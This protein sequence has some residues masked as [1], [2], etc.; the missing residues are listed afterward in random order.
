VRTMVSLDD[1]LLISAKHRSAE[2]NVSLARVIENALRDAVGNP[3]TEGKSKKLIT[4]S[5]TGVKPG[6]DLDSGRSL[7]DIMGDPS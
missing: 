4:A 2:E 6:V 3:R 7:L 5:E 1:Q